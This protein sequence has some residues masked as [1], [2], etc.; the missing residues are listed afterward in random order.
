[1]N[2]RYET[3]N[4]NILTPGAMRD[5]LVGEV[6]SPGTVENFK[7]QN[8]ATH[9]NKKKLLSQDFQKPKSNSKKRVKSA[10]FTGR[11]QD[12]SFTM[13]PKDGNV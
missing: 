7:R 13:S 3:A 2:A 9:K 6:T 10:A 1:M 12:P 11:I 4:L 5:S 8:S